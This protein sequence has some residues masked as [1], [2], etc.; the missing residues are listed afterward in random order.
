MSQPAPKRVCGITKQGDL[1]SVWLDLLNHID[2]PAARRAARLQ[3]E[4]RRDLSSR[5]PS[6]DVINLHAERAIR[7]HAT[8]PVNLPSRLP[9]TSADGVAIEAC[10]DKSGPAGSDGRDR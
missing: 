5:R 6:C 8:S 7:P 4:P 1:L 2:N 3:Q 10:L 9:R